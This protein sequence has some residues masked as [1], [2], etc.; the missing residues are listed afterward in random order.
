VVST[1]RRPPLSRRDGL[2]PFGAAC[3]IRYDG[4]RSRTRSRKRGPTFGEMAAMRCLRRS[5]RACR[6]RSHTAPVHV[7][8]A[9]VGS[10]TRPV[11]CPQRGE[12]LS[13]EPSVS[14]EPPRGQLPVRP[15]SIRD[16][17]AIPASGLL[18][19]LALPQADRDAGRNQ[20][21]GGAR[22]LRLLTGEELLGVR[23]A[24]GALPALFCRTC[25]STLFRGEWPDGEWIGIRLG[26][27]DGDPGIRP[28][29]HMFVDSRADWEELPDDGLPRYSERITAPP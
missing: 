12:S 23:P 19:R 13:R 25:G 9:P 3:S 8:R 20:R 22:R 21:A 15:G 17:K 5:P 4:C 27:L 18:S 28:T 1:D 29:Y 10:R 11:S 24:E 2:R 16:H 7:A 6:S 26:T 14:R